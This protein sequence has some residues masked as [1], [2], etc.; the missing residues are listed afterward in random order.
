M[1]SLFTQEK[2]DLYLVG[3]AEISIGPIR[4]YWY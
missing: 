2:D 4:L 1:L 3:L